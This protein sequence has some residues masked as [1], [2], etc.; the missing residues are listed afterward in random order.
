MNTHVG[1]AGAISP[2]AQHLINGA[3]P[4]LLR[5]ANTDLDKP[6]VSAAL[7]SAAALVQTGGVEPCRPYLG[8]LSEAAARVMVGKAPCQAAESEDEGEGEADAEVSGCG[9]GVLCITPFTLA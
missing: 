7:T 4:L 2:Q 1:N 8:G 3:F 5:A 6:A 9:S